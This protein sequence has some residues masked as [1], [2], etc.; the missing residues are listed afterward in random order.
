MHNKNVSASDVLGSDIKYKDYLGYERPGKIGWIEPYFGSDSNDPDGQI[1]WV[2]V[3]D[4]D[5]DYN[6]HEFIVNMGSMEKPDLRTINYAELRLS[7]EVVL[8]N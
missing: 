1:V 3:V 5:P 6:V 8:D 7:T 2:Y 4:D